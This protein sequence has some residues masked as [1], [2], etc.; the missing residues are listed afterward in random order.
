MPYQNIRSLIHIC[1]KLAASLRHIFTASLLQTCFSYAKF[2][3]GALFW[4]TMCAASMQRTVVAHCSGT[5]CAPQVCSTQ[6]PHTA[7]AH[8]VCRKYAVHSC[9]ALFWHTMCAASLRR[10]VI[11]H[12]SGTQCVPQVCGTQL[13]CTVLFCPLVQAWFSNIIWIFPNS[14]HTCIIEIKY[15]SEQTQASLFVWK[16]APS[17]VLL[18]T[19]HNIPNSYTL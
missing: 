12:Y 16:M 15:W 19:E 3:S 9:R 11:A 8:N 18:S 14:I 1:R 6:F 2:F 10:T 17:H 4:H 5:Q 7:L 13:L